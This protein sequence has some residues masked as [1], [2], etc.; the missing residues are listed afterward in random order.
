LENR[1]IQLEDG[2]FLMAA[3]KYDKL[4]EVISTHTHIQ[5][6]TLEIQQRRVEEYET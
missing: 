1:E 4:L 2:R 5:F 6:K 3:N